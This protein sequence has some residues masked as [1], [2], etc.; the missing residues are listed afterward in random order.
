MKKISSTLL[1]GLSIIFVDNDCSCMIDKQVMHIP[2]SFKNIR[3]DSELKES[4]ENCGPIDIVIISRATKENNEDYLP[5]PAGERN[6]L[7]DIIKKFLFPYERITTN[8]SEK[9]NKEKTDC[10]ETITTMLSECDVFFSRLDNESPFPTQHEA[11]EILINYLKRAVEETEKTNVEVLIAAG[12][13][14]ENSKAIIQHL[15]KGQSFT[16]NN[17]NLFFSEDNSN[18]V[19]SRV[20]VLKKIQA[21]QASFFTKNIKKKVEEDIAN[22]HPAI[23]ALHMHYNK[24][25]VSDL[26]LVAEHISR[27]LSMKKSNLLPEIPI[28]LVFNELFFGKYYPF[29]SGV[30]DN[31]LKAFH[32][33]LASKCSSRLL[34]HVNLLTEGPITSEISENYFPAKPVFF[35]VDIPELDEEKYTKKKANFSTT[36]SKIELRNESILF[37]QADITTQYLKSS[38]CNEANNFMLRPDVFYKFGD[39]KDK[40]SEAVPEYIKNLST[41]T[42]YDIT[43]EARTEATKILVVPSNTLE[44]TNG[45]V[46]SIPPNVEILIHAD[47]NYNGVFLRD[48][49][50]YRFGERPDFDSEKFEDRFTKKAKLIRSI[51]FSV[52]IGEVINV[53][54]ISHY[55][56]FSNM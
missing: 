9:A 47:P 4:F 51:Q 13:S 52:K 40:Y 45:R 26:N 38:Y 55:R 5:L 34:L 3:I 15:E 6:L 39:G 10:S 44:L 42:C 25:P 12:F 11:N 28:L 31:E 19:S 23:N 56:I 7:Y 16:V 54:T 36:A 21:I 20:V 22:E 33:S 27:S 30:L 41:M 18:F 14:K 53:F 29:P 48:T 50:Y 32:Q 2:E 1:L 24:N 17:K 35:K 46:Y 43:S 49:E 37:G 8:F